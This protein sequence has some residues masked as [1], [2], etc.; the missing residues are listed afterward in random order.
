MRNESCVTNTESLRFINGNLLRKEEFNS[1]M[2]LSCLICTGVCALRQGD[3]FAR[4]VRTSHVLAR[5]QL[6][7]RVRLCM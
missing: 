4:L 3:A 2:I 5:D 7:P 1:E 6:A